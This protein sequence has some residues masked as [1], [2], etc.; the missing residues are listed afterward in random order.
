MDVAAVVDDNAP[1][2]APVDRPRW[3][4]N[5]PFWLMHGLAI[6]GVAWVGWS[7][8]ALPW[9][10]GGYAVRMFGVTAGYHRYF[11]H[12][13]YKA[14][15]GMQLF[16][17]IIGA[18]AAQK[19]PLWWAGHHRRHHKH[20]D[21]PTDVH[22]PRHHGVWGSHL[23]WF[24]GPRHV[25]TDLSALPDIARFPE[26]RFVDRFHDLV[27]LGA[28]A[29]TFLLGGTTG[30]VWG[31]FAAIVLCW[32]STFTIN[33][34]AHVWGKRR[35]PTSD[36]SRNNAFLAII[37]FGEGWHNNHH[38]YQRSARQGFYWWEIDISYYVLKAFEAVGLVREV[39][40]VPAHVRDRHA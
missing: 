31:G 8:A 30:L 1:V 40:G 11:A 9:L 5:S 28:L 36:D 32:H 35:Y 33:S 15:R 24:L 18:S 17:A 21:L 14:G 37:T 16:L 12:R 39:S 27:I 29:L 4:R 3:L 38:H 2:A 7:W 10:A 25:K 34:L 6:V 26:I 23:G 20:S 13:S 22:S 19:G